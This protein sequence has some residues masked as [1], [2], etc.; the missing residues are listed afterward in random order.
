LHPYPVKCP[1]IKEINMP[2]WKVTGHFCL[3]IEDVETEQEAKEQAIEQ[4]GDAY[5]HLSFEDVFEVKAELITEE[6]RM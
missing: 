2:T 5:I 3:E 6:G 1:K 4:L